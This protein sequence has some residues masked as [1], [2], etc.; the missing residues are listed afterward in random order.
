[1]NLRESFLIIVGSLALVLACGDSAGPATT[2][3]A[4]TAAPQCYPGM[5]ATTLR[6]GAAVCMTQFSNGYCTHYCATDADCCAIPGECPSGHPEV[7]G[8]FESTNEMYCFLSCETN[9]VTAAG[10]TDATLFC[11]TYANRDFICRST[12]GG[13]LNRQICAPKG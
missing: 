9:D 6:G 8:P 11:Q 7:C 4:C 3:Q 10:F 13:S 5:D 1:M 12:G 2:G